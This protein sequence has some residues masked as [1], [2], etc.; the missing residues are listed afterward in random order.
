MGTLTKDV[1]VEN[2]HSKGY[3]MKEGKVLVELLLEEIKQVLEDGKEVKIANFGRW[4]VR[5]KKSR[6]GRNPHTGER[7]EI[8]E[9]RVV[10][11]YSSKAFREKFEA[12]ADAN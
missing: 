9:R 11:F 8:S 10:T 2:L 3:Q 4:N 6:S 12:N 1:L 7:I 5:H